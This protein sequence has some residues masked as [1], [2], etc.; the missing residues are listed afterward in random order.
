MKE[1]FNTDH[2]NWQD[3][4]AIAGTVKDLQEQGYTVK[5][6]EDRYP[7]SITRAHSFIIVW[8]KKSRT[9][10]GY[11]AGNIPTNGVAQIRR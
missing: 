9:P 4:W 8:Y 1:I 3:D 5:V 6:V 11:A 10:A 2:E 7:R